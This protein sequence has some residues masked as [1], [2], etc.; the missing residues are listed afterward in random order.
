MA[1]DSVPDSLVRRLLPRGI[2]LA[3][4]RTKHFRTYHERPKYAHQVGTRSEHGVRGEPMAIVMQG[5]IAAEYNFTLETLRIYARHMPECRLILSTWKDTPKDQLDPIAGLGVEIILSDRPARPGLYNVNMQLISAAAGVRRAAEAGAEW[6]LKTRTDQ[7]LYNPDAMGFLMATARTFPVGGNCKQR[8]RIVG[9]GHGS[10]KFA[11]YH[12]TDQTVFGHAEDM[13]A[14]WTPALREAPPPMHWPTTPLDI[15]LKVP[16]GEVCRYGAAETYIASEFLAR[17]GR[18]LEWT[19]QDTWAAYRDHFC[20]VDYEATDFF[21]V[22]SQSSTLREF[23][24]RYDVKWTRNEVNFR[25]WLLLHSGLLPCEAAARYES[26]L[27]QYFT[28]PINID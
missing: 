6:I 23:S 4:K 13:L 25:E 1:K 14:Y 5:P 3:N 9:V 24:V 16:I 27:D 11:P 17:I 28:E 26:V 7:R 19:L 15:Y 10:L 8:Y 21:W 2:S 22:K 12:V 20:F 18:P